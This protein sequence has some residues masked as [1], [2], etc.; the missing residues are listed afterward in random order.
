MRTTGKLERLW[1]SGYIQVFVLG[2]FVAMLSFLVL[3]I[4]GDGIF[5]LGNDFNEQQIPFH[6]L[7]N[8]AVKSGN[9]GWNWSIDLGS[10]FI[11]AFG[12]Y[13]MGSPFAWISF[14]FSAEHYPY[15]T[16][17]LYMAKY[18]VAAVCAYS[19]LKRFTGK[20]YAA[21]GAMLYAFAGFQ[22]VNLIFHHF[23]DAV[24]FFP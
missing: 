1:K 16:G 4:R 5:T 19:Y 24:A 15:V 3:L 10:N 14:L 9:I 6:M 21:L 13:L 17:W 18:A 23:H 22:S 7:A 12:F 20:K 2:Y 11:G 8:R